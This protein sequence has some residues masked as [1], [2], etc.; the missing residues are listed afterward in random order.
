MGHSGVREDLVPFPE[1]SVGRDQ[2][3]SLPI[4]ADGEHL[5][6]QVAL[7]LAERRIPDLIHDEDGRALGDL[8]RAVEALGGLR[9]AEP[10]HPSA[11]S[12]VNSTLRPRW[13]CA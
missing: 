11:A 10:V 9:G 2:R 6:E 8:E 7:G 3:W 13:H 12:E 4:V 5:E 1:H